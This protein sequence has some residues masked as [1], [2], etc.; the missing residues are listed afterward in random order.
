LRHRTMPDEIVVKSLHE[1]ASELYRPERQHINPFA[2]NE[3]RK[4]TD[5]RQNEGKQFKPHHFP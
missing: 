4:N 5:E 1:S 3:Q 2:K